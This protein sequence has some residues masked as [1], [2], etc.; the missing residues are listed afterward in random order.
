MTTWLADAPT[1]WANVLTVA[2]SLALL[3]VVWSLP[4]DEVHGDAPEARWRDLRLW[5][6]ALIALQL[7]IYALFS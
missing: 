6:T 1:V 4:R 3:A 5:A 7:A 2:L